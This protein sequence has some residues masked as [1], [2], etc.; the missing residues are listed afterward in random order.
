MWRYWNSKSSVPVYREVTSE[1]MCMRARYIYKLYWTLLQPYHTWGHFRTIA[2]ILNTRIAS[3]LAKALLSMNPSIS[4]SD[5][6]PIDLRRWIASAVLPNDQHAHEMQTSQQ[7][8]L[9]W[10]AFSGSTCRPTV[11]LYPEEPFKFIHQSDRL[12]ANC[13]HFTPNYI[14]YAPTFLI[15]PAHRRVCWSNHQ[16]L[17]LNQPTGDTLAS[18]LSVEILCPAVW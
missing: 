4:G 9:I 8:S 10:L 14:K 15:G 3:W 2:F 5:D 16:P 12:T 1:Y 7:I 13:D 11:S 6:A 17:A 18:A